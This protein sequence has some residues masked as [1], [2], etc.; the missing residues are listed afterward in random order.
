MI[1]AT[2]SSPSP[3]IP[4]TSSASSSSPDILVDRR[5]YPSIAFPNEIARGTS[6]AVG[7]TLVKP[8][9]METPQILNTLVRM[10]TEWTEMPQLK[11]TRR[12]AQRLWSLSNEACETAFATLIRKGFLVQAPDGAYVRHAFVRVSASIAAGSPNPSL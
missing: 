5:F 1:D 2:R 12:Q 8:G 4:T 10:Q 3:D 11:I 6:R 9:D 7:V